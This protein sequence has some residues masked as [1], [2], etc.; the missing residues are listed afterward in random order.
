MLL[1]N[2]KSCATILP[3]TPTDGDPRQ[4]ETPERRFA[5]AVSTLNQFKN[6][7]LP[8]SSFL[9]TAFSQLPRLLSDA[10][11]EKSAN[12]PVYYEIYGLV[13]D[14]QTAI[15][16]I[17]LKQKEGTADPKT[18][19]ITAKRSN[20]SQRDHAVSLSITTRGGKF[21]YTTVVLNYLYKSDEVAK[22]ERTLG[23]D[24]SS[25]VG[26][27]QTPAR[28]PGQVDVQRPTRAMPPHQPG[29][30][31]AQ[32]FHRATQG[33]AP[34]AP[35]PTETPAPVPARR[36]QP[37]GRILA[38]AALPAIPRPIDQPSAEPVRE[39]TTAE[40]LLAGDPTACATASRDEL[41]TALHT[42]Q[43]KINVLGAKNSKYSEIASLDAAMIELAYWLMKNKQISAR[44]VEWQSDGFIPSYGDGTAYPL[45]LRD[46]VTDTVI[47]VNVREG[48]TKNGRTDMGVY[49]HNLGR[50]NAVRAAL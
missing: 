40:K 22:I 14:L 33:E 35:R 49:N 2:G 4:L 7:R 3:M 38:Q 5:N 1:A 13:N 21:R 30:R 34:S 44:D 24:T 11:D 9:P 25:T 31:P 12:N 39:L 28:R 15:V 42:L 47:E 41:F 29:Q 48:S 6:G 17:A 27:P 23:L 26:N 36:D 50:L 19:I 32:P 18:P 45:I 37:N 43:M 16:G 20:D 8:E 46:A 10:R